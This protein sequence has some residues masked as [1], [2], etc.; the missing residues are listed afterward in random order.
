MK[1]KQSLRLLF[2]AQA[3]LCLSIGLL[4]ALWPLLV[5]PAFHLNGRLLEDSLVRMLGIYLA[6]LGLLL[7][8][9][10]D[11][12]GAKWPLLIANGFALVIILLQQ[13]AIWESA[14]GWA[15]VLVILL[16][17]LS[18]A[19]VCWRTRAI[20]ATWQRPQTAVEQ[21]I[22][23]NAI[24]LLLFGAAFV[25]GLYSA[26]GLRF[27][28]QSLG[29]TRLIGLALMGSGLL[30]FAYFTVPSSD[31]MTR[32]AIWLALLVGNL[33]A[34]L[35]ASIQ[36]MAVWNNLAGWL[37]ATGH[38]LLATMLFGA[39]LL[40][41]DDKRSPLPKLR[42]LWRSLGVGL[43][44]YLSGSFLLV[45]LAAI[46]VNEQLAQIDGLSRWIMVGETAVLLGLLLTAPFQQAMHQIGQTV[47]QLTQQQ[48]ASA[49]APTWPFTQIMQRLQELV[50][51]N[52]QSQ[53]L[54][55]R[56]KQQIQDATAQE[57][58][59]RLA[60]DLHDSIKQQVFAIN[61]SAAA[62]QTRWQT[63]PA[64]A[65]AAL[66][67][68]RHSAQAAM[69]EM[70]AMLQQLRP[71]P[72][73]NVG[74]V[75]ALQEQSEA[76]A[77]RSGA[78]VTTA[79][80]PLPLSQWWGDGAQTAVFRIAQEALA[81]IAR[82]ARASQVQV[83][84]ELVGDE[85]EAALCLRISDNGQ[86]FDPALKAQAG[87]GLENMQ[88][89]AQAI[90]AEFSI[91]SAPSQGTTVQLLVPLLPTPQMEADSTLLADQ[92]RMLRNGVISVAV[93]ALTY[94]LLS[95][96]NVM[97]RPFMLVM[98]TALVFGLLAVTLM[99]NSQLRR[100]PL[101]AP[102]LAL[103]AR[104]YILQAVALLGIFFVVQA[105]PLIFP[106]WGNALL[107]SILLA[108][109]I[110]ILFGYIMGRLFL[111]L[112]DRYLLLPLAQQKIFRG[113]V[114]QWR[115]VGWLITAVLLL[116]TLAS[117]LFTT[118]SLPPVASAQWL[119]NLLISATL[120][121]VMIQIGLGRLVKIGN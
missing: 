35:M 91:N 93:M 87:M 15:L 86:G 63:D 80:C 26:I 90:D 5:Y 81:N 78:K 47:T 62:A 56:L 100:V 102:K 67:D 121:A 75:Q 98:M 13:I 84:L 23:L 10:R 1:A 55:G 68:V 97:E 3:I 27:E 110:M 29:S 66:A 19:A 18:S 40:W 39:W 48:E 43:A 103:Q 33:L 77:L 30:A 83:S 11:V 52:Q 58:R 60:R 104:I 4:L 20:P 24:L 92:S 37:V 88:A 12:V 2:S 53:Q 44:L 111:T 115:Q 64:G 22:S 94:A 117:L 70:N 101:S 7:W 96:A 69:V 21:V 89:R 16:L 57:E 74:L 31:Q 25:F 61:V 95:L 72:L 49:P 38:G 112:R 46:F 17:T 71:S 42:S 107:V 45:A 109:L 116:N 118:P 8:S 34:F 50:N 6:G 85:Q 79:F 108:M 82:H 28:Q 65:Q 59:N 114:R 99:A 120:V 105:L 41:S 9:L 14:F 76:L 32:R 73:E 36:E 106:W 119:Q 54:R 113:Q 51:Q